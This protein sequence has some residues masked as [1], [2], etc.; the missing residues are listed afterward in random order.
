MHHKR[1]GPKQ[2]RSGCMLCKPNKNSHNVSA[3][4][5]KAKKLAFKVELK[6]Y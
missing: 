5:A 1:K 3:D 2:S 6:A 4:R